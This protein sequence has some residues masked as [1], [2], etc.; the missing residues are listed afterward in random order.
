MINIKSDHKIAQVSII[1][2]SGRVVKTSS[3][4]SVN[5][6]NLAKGAYLV[7]VKYADGTTETKKVIKK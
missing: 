2:I 3:E 6:E 5:V 7:S 1:D 4:S